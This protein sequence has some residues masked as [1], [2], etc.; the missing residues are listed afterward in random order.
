MFFHPYASDFHLEAGY[1]EA[2]LIIH[3]FSGTPGQVRPLGNAIFKSGIDVHAILL[4]GHGTDVKELSGVRWQQ[5]Y[6]DVEDTYLKLKEKYEKVYVTGFSLGGVL[7][8]LLSEKHQP[9]KIVLIS[10]PV[11][12]HNA[13]LASLIPVFRYFIRYASFHK[14]GKLKVDL[15]DVDYSKFPVTSFYEVLKA[16]RAATKNLEKV[17]GKILIIQSFNDEAV[18]HESADIIY[19]RI[20]SEDKRIFRLQNSM[21]LCVLGQDRQLVFNE[22]RNF[23]KEE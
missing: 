10:T 1:N 21:H 11:K 8:L 18:K 19:H 12:I 14:K 20:S 15:Y 17:T 6:A 7:T 13:F 9:D 3:G 2:C 5:W 16:K 4:K 23:L 22:V